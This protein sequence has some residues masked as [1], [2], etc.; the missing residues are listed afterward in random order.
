MIKVYVSKQANYPVSTPFVKKV[1]KDFF[2][3]NGIVSDAEVNV[4]IVG[5]EKMKKFAKEY[6]NENNTVHN[7]LSFNEEEVKNLFV[8]PPDDSIRLGQIIICY[9]KAHEEAVKEGK[10]VN[11]KIKELLEHGAD[12]LLG[13]HHE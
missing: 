11:Q 12:H 8:Y 6:L 13:R 5:P 2:T 10:V 3:K 7:V 4:S 1:L 9:Q